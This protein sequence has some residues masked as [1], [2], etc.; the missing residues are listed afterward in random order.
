MG[1]AVDA[2]SNAVKVVRTIVRRREVRPVAA[3]ACTPRNDVTFPGRTNT[4]DRYCHFLFKC[5][6]SEQPYRS[7]LCFGNEVVLD[8]HP[9]PCYR[10]QR[11]HTRSQQKEAARFRRGRAGRGRLHGDVIQSHIAGIIL[12]AEADGVAARSYFREREVLPLVVEVAGVGQAEH[13][14]SVPHRREKLGVVPARRPDR[15]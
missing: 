5:G 12:K 4:C 9:A 13:R 3:S 7:K 14:G 10:P 6:K 1:S 11:Q 8:A 2:I 15:S